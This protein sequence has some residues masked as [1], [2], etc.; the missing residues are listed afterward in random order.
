MNS[1]AMYAEHHGTVPKHDCKF[2]Y[3][4]PGRSGATLPPLNMAAS[5]TASAK[6]T[7]KATSLDARLSHKRPCSSRSCLGTL[8]LLTGPLRTQAANS[9]KKLQLH[10]ETMRAHAGW[11][12]EPS[13]T[14]VISVLAEWRCGHIIRVPYHS[15]MS[16]PPSAT[17]TC[18][19]A[20]IPCSPLPK[21]SHLEARNIIKGLFYTIK[22]G[23][24]LLNS[25]K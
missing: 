22:F 9:V 12:S 18:G 13:P 1:P 24:G 6:T 21:F 15:L 3:V 10:R 23:V 25:N 2:L 20:K 4:V 11:Q 5:G 8:T 17:V 19:R 16:D 14:S 7:T